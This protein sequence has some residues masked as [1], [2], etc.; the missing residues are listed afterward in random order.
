MHSQRSDDKPKE[1]SFDYYASVLRN[2]LTMSD[3]DSRYARY[4]SIEFSRGSHPEKR[5]FNLLERKFGENFISR[6]LPIFSE[7]RGIEPPVIKWSA[8]ESDERSSRAHY[9]NVI[10]K[11]MMREILDSV[12]Q[13]RQT[14]GRA[15]LHLSHLNVENLKSHPYGKVL[16]N[17]P[18]T[19]GGAEDVDMD[20]WILS[21]FLPEQVLPQHAIPLLYGR[22]SLSSTNR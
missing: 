12:N 10:E 4:R 11:T 17:R 13:E 5:H 16:L 6:R 1:D 22:L 8:F 15:P 7:K 14:Q 9:E 21:Q 20:P 19:T 2:L 18:S 3:A